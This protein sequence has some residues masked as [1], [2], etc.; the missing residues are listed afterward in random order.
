MVLCWGRF[1]SVLSVVLKKEKMVL[2]MWECH[3]FEVSLFDM[4]LWTYGFINI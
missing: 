3:N 1:V 2:L 4:W